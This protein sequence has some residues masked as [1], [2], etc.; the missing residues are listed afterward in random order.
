M[1]PILS[2]TAVALIVVGLIGQGFELR[3]IR[4][5]ITKDE[6]LTSKNMFTNK[7]NLKWYLII[8]AGLVLWYAGRQFS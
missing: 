7:R 2:F 5:S 4:A 6:D 1:E 3:K 8:G